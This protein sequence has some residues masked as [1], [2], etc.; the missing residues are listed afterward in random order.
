MNPKVRIETV[1]VKSDIRRHHQLGH[2]PD[3]QPKRKLDTSKAEKEFGFNATTDF[4]EGLRRTVDWYIKQRNK[5]HKAIYK[6]SYGA[7]FQLLPPATHRR[8]LDNY[9]Q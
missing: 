4:V 7:L 3:G 6:P 8:L 5:G 2:Q 9:A 1:L